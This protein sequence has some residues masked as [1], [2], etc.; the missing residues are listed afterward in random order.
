LEIQG[1]FLCDF[2]HTSEYLGAAAPTG[3]AGQADRWRRTQQ[4]RLKRGAL[5]QVI[6]SMEPHLEP[7]GTADEEAPVRHAHRYVSHRT[8]CLDSPQALEVGLPIGSGMMESGHRPVLPARLKQA[9]AAWLKDHADQIA[10]WRVLRSNG[11]GSVLW[12]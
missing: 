9:G 12:N 10:H 1:H 7:V 11:R 8:E 4:Q 3:Q 6:E 2:F 5:Q